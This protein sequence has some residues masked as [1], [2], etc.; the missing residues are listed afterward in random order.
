ME[1]IRFKTDFHAS[2][3]AVHLK[4]TGEEQNGRYCRFSIL[5]NIL[6]IFNLKKHIVDFQS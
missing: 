6:S 3:T 2:F 4:C 5:K 1:D